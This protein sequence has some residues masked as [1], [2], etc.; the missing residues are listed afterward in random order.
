VLE[1]ELRGG[2][3]SATAA[4][5]S[6]NGAPQVLVLGG[7][8]SRAVLRGAR[9][10]GAADCL[11]SDVDMISLVAAVHALASPTEPRATVPPCR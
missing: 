10:A 11:T 6:P 9:L 4:I 7:R 1:R 8:G 2:G 3:L 5:A